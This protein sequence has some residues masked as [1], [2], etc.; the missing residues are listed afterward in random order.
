[1]AY[2][3]QTIA[4]TVLDHTEVEGYR[5]RT[6]QGNDEIESDQ[7]KAFHVVGLSISVRKAPSTRSADP[8][9]E[10]DDHVLQNKVDKKHR[11][12]KGDG[13]GES[14]LKRGL[15][16]R[17]PKITKAVH[18]SKSSKKRVSSC[19][20]LRRSRDASANGIWPG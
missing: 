4:V 13:L 6:S 1:M 2:E 14:R 5:I 20:E 12:K 10:R 3:T 8:A 17:T 11:D 9:R 15:G 16:T 7:H 18:T 19:P